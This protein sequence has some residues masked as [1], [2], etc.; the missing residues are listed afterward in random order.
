MK[1]QVAYV[2]SCGTCVAMVI[3]KMVKNMIQLPASSYSLLC[4]YPTPVFGTFQDGTEG[5]LPGEMG[6]TLTCVGRMNRRKVNLS[7]ERCHHCQKKEGSPR[8]QE[9][10]P[11]INMSELLVYR[12]QSPI[13]QD[14]REAKSEVF[15][16]PTSP[17]IKSEQ[18]SKIIP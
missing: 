10:K 8:N 4:G 18:V 16:H 2:W 7:V 15:F 6:P 1:H 12:F 11:F 5:H 9:R 17:N 13:H 3:S 14:Y